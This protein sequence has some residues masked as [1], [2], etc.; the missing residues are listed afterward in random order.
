V[1]NKK[2]NDEPHL[3]LN[4]ETKPIQ[5]IEWPTGALMVVGSF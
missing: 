1:V 2:N 3:A 5:W 4:E